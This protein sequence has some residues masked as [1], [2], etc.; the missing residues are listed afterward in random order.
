[1]I[2]YHFLIS[3]L[4]ASVVSY[5]LPYNQFSLD[6]RL[7]FL[8]D[9][10]TVPLTGGSFVFCD[11]ETFSK[12]LSC[13]LPPRI[14]FFIST[15][16][17]PLPEHIPHNLNYIAVNL[18]YPVLCTRTLEILQNYRNL[19]DRLVKSLP[20][21]LQ[22]ESYLK[23]IS[24]LTAS[25]C[26]LFNEKQEPLLKASACDI[27]PPA[28]EE[29]QSLIRQLSG[30]SGRTLFPDGNAFYAYL[31]QQTFHNR[32]FYLL[33]ASPTDFSQADIRWV[34]SEA[35]DHLL[36][37]ISD[38]NI[39][40]YTGHEQAVSQF[41]GEIVDGPLNNWNESLERYRSLKPETS[42]FT[43]VVYVL[44][45]YPSDALTHVFLL[46]ELHKLF[47]GY[48]MGPYQNDLIIF[49]PNNGKKSRL[50]LHNPEFNRIL[51]HYSAFAGCSMWTKYRFRTSI[52]LAQA[53]AKF[54][55]SLRL[56]QD[57]RI[58]YHDDYTIYH[59][60]DLAADSFREVHR[61]KDLTYLQHPAVLRIN[62]YDRDHNTNLLEILYYYLLNGCSVNETAA[63]LNVHR[64]TI[65]G[66]I[67]K[68]NELI[69]ED[70]V[71]S[72]L[73]QCRLLLSCMIFFYQNRYLKEPFTRP[74]SIYYSFKNLDV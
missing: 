27:K 68:L 39:P 58:F 72:G 47:P 71:R 32:N 10:L 59:M 56:E 54:G 17:M 40:L 38:Y 35:L 16:K 25:A 51:A 13:P 74:Q 19:N 70:F 53:N 67:N 31:E 22:L 52:I 14:C 50:N 42:D 15:A 26:F 33:F 29:V 21:K 23:E 28:E 48:L 65:Q 34:A 44:L 41:I 36:N 4:A 60:I 63:R 66:K 20:N 5:Q 46:S 3:K 24:E 6:C 30:S 7:I 18:S 62:N 45:P 8:D 73:I 49:V 37:S 69:R 64:N 57:S 12:C 11:S 61:S 43:T 55:K 2:T 9:Q 1:M